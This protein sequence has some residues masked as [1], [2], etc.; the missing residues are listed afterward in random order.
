MRL[1]L[2]PP[3]WGLASAFVLV[4]VCGGVVSAQPKKPLKADKT[5]PAAAPAPL[6]KPPGMQLAAATATP[7]S[8]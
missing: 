3:L 7:N 5:E 2:V 1:R 6:A 4:L 8:S